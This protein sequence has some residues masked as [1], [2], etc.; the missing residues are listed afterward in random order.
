MVCKAASVALFW[1]PIGLNELPEV[2]LKVPF[3]LIGL[4]RQWLFQKA[5]HGMYSNPGT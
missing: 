4:N 1:R 5:N 2:R 3:F